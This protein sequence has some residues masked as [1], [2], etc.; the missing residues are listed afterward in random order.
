L[1]SRHS[2]A[3]LQNSLTG[4]VRTFDGKPVQ[5]ARVE[6]R[7]VST[8]ETIASGYTLPNGSFEFTDVPQGTYEVVA[9]LGLDQT[10]QRVEL[11][12]PDPGIQL[13]LSGDH[14]DPATAGNAIVSV[15][16]MKVPEKAKKLFEKA[17]QAFQKQKLSQAR[18]QVEKALQAFPAYAQALTLR[19]ILNLQ[20]N[21]VDAARTDLEQAIKHDYSYGL[22]YLVLGTTYNLMKR[23]DDSVRTL[24]RGIALSPSSWQGYFELSKAFL[25]KGDF[26]AALRQINKA[27]EFGP[28]NYSA[29]HLVRAHALL[30]MKDYNQAV[31]ELEQFIGSNPTAADSARARETLNQVKAFMGQGK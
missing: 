24:Q 23:F 15:A 2:G 14:A 13:T 10:H 19:G 29:I 17:D 8:A 21:K 11:Y 25:G 28:A 3:A 30:G 26:P 4:T 27:A 22:S 20:D 1:P 6:L 7:T 12:Q 31:V 9:T 18:E 5:N 16:Q